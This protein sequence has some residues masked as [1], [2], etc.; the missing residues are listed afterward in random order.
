MPVPFV[1]KPTAEGPGRIPL[2][3]VVFIGVEQAVKHGDGRQDAGS[4]PV[5]WLDRRV[6]RLLGT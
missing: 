2:A 4:F 6:H 1:Q 3:V 5:Q